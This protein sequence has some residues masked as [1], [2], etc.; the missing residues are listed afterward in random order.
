MTFEREIYFILKKANKPMS[1]TEVIKAIELEYCGDEKE[2]YRAYE[3]RLEGFAGECAWYGMS[4]KERV[5]NALKII[6]GH[7][8]AKT[9][10]EKSQMP[11]WK[12]KN[13]VA[14]WKEYTYRYYQAIK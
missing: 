9:W 3:N 6:V 14:N 4:I 10:T 7:K 13:P 12:C 11:S 8:Y 5:I 2:D 1:T